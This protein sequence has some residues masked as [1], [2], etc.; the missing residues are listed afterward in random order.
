MAIDWTP[1]EQ[2]AV[3]AG[4]RRFTAE[5]GMCA[6]LARIVFAEGERRDPCTAAMQIHP[7]SPARFIVPKSS[8]VRFWHS[9]TY[10]E[11]HAHAVDALTGTFGC[12]SA[13]Y[14]GEH[15][16]YPTQLDVVVVDVVG[17]DAGIEDT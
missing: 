6:A 10:V 12:E 11:T 14:L 5:T 15:W 9:H 4:M 3:D 13:S 8:H 16:R 17:V 7:K 2:Q 1:D